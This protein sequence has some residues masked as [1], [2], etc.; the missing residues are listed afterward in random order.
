M[1]NPEPTNQATKRD[2]LKLRP[3]TR[4]MQ[5]FAMTMFFVFGAVATV[6]VLLNPFNLGFLPQLTGA[7]AEQAT[8]VP[9]G[10][11]Q[12]YQCPMHPDVIEETPANCPIC[13]MKLTPMK[14]SVPEASAA[15]G[16]REILY[17]YA[18]MD[19]AYIRDAP[20]KSPMGMDLVPKYADEGDRVGVIRIDPVQIQNSGVVS[21]QARLGEIDRRIS[22]VGFLDFNA[23]DITWINTKFDG[24]IEQVHV[25][26][27]GQEVKKGDALFDIYSPELVTTQEEYLRALDY[28]QSLASSDREE[29]RRQA[30]SLLRSTRERLTYWDISEEQINALET[31]QQTQR[32]LTVYSPAD[33]VVSEIMFGGNLLPS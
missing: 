5:L 25:S 32:R 26:Y 8:T 18:P 7:P 4:G 16:E 31:R 33:G 15:G 17:W 20:G 3:M 23:D 13:L 27:V 6:F 2:A 29:A 21:E 1:T 11:K 22:T 10:P 12:L 19:S 30:D 24:W 9:T 14:P 28:K